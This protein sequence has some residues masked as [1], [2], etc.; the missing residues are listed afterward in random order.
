MFTLAYLDVLTEG[1]LAGGKL[2]SGTGTIDADGSV[3]RID[4]VDLKVEG[5][6]GAGAAVF[7]VPE[8]IQAQAVQAARGRIEVVPVTRVG[9]AVDWLC[10]NGGT[11]SVC[12]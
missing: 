7:L 11:S 9:D 8:E 3:G 4:G 6:V 1:D 12:G 10:A 2:V 5:A